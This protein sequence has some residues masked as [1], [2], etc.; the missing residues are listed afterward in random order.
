[1]ISFLTLWIEGLGPILL[2]IP[3]RIS[4]FRTIALI[5]F[6]GLHLGILLTLHLGNFPW[7]CFALWIPIIPS[8]FW[9]YLRPKTTMSHITLYYDFECGFCRRFCFFVQEFFGLGRMNVSASNSNSDIHRIVDGEKSWC[10]SIGEKT[11]I[12]F[13]VITQII[14]LTKFSFI[15]KVLEIKPILEIGNFFYRNISKHRFTIGKFLNSNVSSKL[16]I[17]EHWFKKIIIVFIIALSTAWNFEGYLG[18]NT[19]DIKTPF[20]DTAF[21]LGLNQQWNMFAPKPMSDDGWVVVEG[22]MSDNQKWD[23]FNNK[24]VSFDRPK[25]IQESVD[26]TQWRKLFVNLWNK[27]YISYRPR[28]TKYICRNWNEKNLYKVNHVNVFFML[29]RTLPEES[30]D[31]MLVSK[32]LMWEYTC[33]E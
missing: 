25:Y 13:E 26:G 20:S 28:L 29:E 17:E 33:K 12:R 3:F 31:E 30:K 4:F 7:A 15:G 11:Y 22:T 1:M 16:Q 21:I 24:K 27:D 32:T 9:E 23:V 14:N 2:L 10:L 8:S 6:I 5:L 19:F 18:T